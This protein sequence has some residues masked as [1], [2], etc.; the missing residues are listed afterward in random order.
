MYDAV[1]EVRRKNLPR[2]GFFNVK[3]GRGDWLVAVAIERVNQLDDIFLLVTLKYQRIPG[4]PLVFATIPVGA[5]DLLKAEHNHTPP[6][7]RFQTFERV[8]FFQGI[9]DSPKRTART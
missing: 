7:Q 6:F 3:A 2:L 5:I 1:A 8:S 4:I 9:D